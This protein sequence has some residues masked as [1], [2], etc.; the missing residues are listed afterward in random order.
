MA[1]YELVEERLI[2]GKGVLR[3]PDNPVKNRSAVLYLDV[4]REPRNKYV[5]L[6]WN[7]YRSR[8]ASLVFRRDDYVIGTATMEFEQQAY[9][10]I[11]DISGQNLIAIKCM[12]EGILISFVNL[13]VAQGFVLT[14]YTDLIKDYESLSLGWEEVLIQ[15]YADT[16]IQARLYRLE[17][18]FCDPDKNK[19][20]KPPPPPPRLPKVPP[21]TSIGDISRPYDD[22]DDDGNTVPYEGDDTPPPPPEMPEDGNIN[23]NFS[24]VRVPRVTK[25]TG[26]FTAQAPIREYQ[27]TDIINDDVGINARNWRAQFRY[28]SGGGAIFVGSAVGNLTPEDKPVMNIWLPT[29]GNDEPPYITLYP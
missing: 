14:S 29:Q 27:V 10:S 16:A 4:I 25:A 17:Y 1:D 28:G 23:W 20:R 19:Q 15:C 21:G 24:T 7:P 18:D 9:D 5:N 11:A 6:N 3:V 12:Y 2:S 8:F 13:A 26:A 22:D